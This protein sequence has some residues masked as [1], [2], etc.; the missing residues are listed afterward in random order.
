LLS[1]VAAPENGSPRRGN[2]LRDDVEVLRIPRNPR[3]EGFK[4][5]SVSGLDDSDDGFLRRLAARAG[6][7]SQ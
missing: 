2:A 4:N 6:H 5:P 3:K 1:G 7:N